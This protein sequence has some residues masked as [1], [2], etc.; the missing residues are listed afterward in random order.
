MPAP[1]TSCCRQWIDKLNATEQE[2]HAQ[3][4][5]A[6]I[7]AGQV[8]GVVEILDFALR[9]MEAGDPELMD[10]SDDLNVKHVRIARDTLARSLNQYLDPH[11]P[12]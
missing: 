2:Q 12:F 1:D 4:I 3:T 11:K 9:L 6:A 7:L 8:C 10:A 5:R